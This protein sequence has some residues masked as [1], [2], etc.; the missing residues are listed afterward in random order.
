MK[1]ERS[2]RWASRFLAQVIGIMELAE[3]ERPRNEFQR[4]NILLSFLFI[5]KQCL[6]PR[7]T[8]CFQE[9]F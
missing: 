9:M 1:C 8:F 7:F 5:P 6:S 4:E 2:Q 3:M